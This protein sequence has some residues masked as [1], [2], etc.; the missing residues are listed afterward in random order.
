MEIGGLGA[1]G[2]L[3]IWVLDLDPQKL[4]SAVFHLHSFFLKSQA[5]NEHWV[6]FF[7]TLSSLSGGPLHIL[8]P[9]LVVRCDSGVHSV[10]NWLQLVQLC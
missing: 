4:I 2:G 6:F 9:L 7:H 8:V 1:Q 10:G 5:P 3:V